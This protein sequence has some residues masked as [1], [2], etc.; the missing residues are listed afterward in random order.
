MF[1]MEASSVDDT[2][3]EKNTEGISANSKAMPPVSTKLAYTYFI[4]VVNSSGSS[5]ILFKAIIANSGI[6]NSAT[7]KMDATVRNLA[8]IGT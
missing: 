5:V 1:F 6:V 2:K 7:T 3:S 8:Y 4:F